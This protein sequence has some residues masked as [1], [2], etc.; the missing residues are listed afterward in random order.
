LGTN[1]APTTLSLFM[2]YG[3]DK[4]DDET[5]CVIL[6]ITISITIANG[7]VFRSNDVIHVDAVKI[8]HQVSLA[9]FCARVT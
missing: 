4:D 5:I 2:A 1:N 9:A 7:H 3:I 8:S 6:T